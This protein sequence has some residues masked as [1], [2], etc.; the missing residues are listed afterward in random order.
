MLKG[1]RSA[2]GWWMGAATHGD[3]A[4]SY[5]L[6]ARGSLS[7]CVESVARCVVR[8]GGFQR[9]RPF[10]VISCCSV[11]RHSSIDRH[12]T[13]RFL[14]KPTTRVTGPVL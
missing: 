7:L 4:A 13:L 3:K 2:A 5:A 9:V 10:S 14:R 6:I 12:L 8:R 1:V 11:R